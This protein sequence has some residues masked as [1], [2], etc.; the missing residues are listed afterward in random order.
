M[1]YSQQ[2]KQVLKQVP[3]IGTRSAIDRKVSVF[4]MVES[5]KTTV[6]GFLE[7]T[8]ID[9]TQP[10]NPKGKG[11]YFIPKERTSGI[12]ATAS[13]LRN[14]MF[15]KPTPMGNIF[16]ADF[17]MRWETT[18][19]RQFVRLP[20]AETAGEE[21]QKLIT[22]FQEGQ[23]DLSTRDFTQAGLIYEN[24]LRANGFIIIAPCTRIQGRDGTAVEEET[25][26]VKDPDVNIARLLECIYN[27][28]QDTQSGAPG[29]TGIAVLLTKYD[30]MAPILTEQGMDLTSPIG[31]QNFMSTHFK[32]TYAILKWYG[33]NKVRFWPTWVELERDRE[34]NLLQNER[35]YQIARHG[36][37]RVP[38]Y[39]CPSYLELIDWVRTTFP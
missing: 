7:L 16:E 19:N 15:P 13:D 30:A 4:G 22:R 36:G 32:E 24:I 9:L 25:A 14:G 10:G 12:R 11:F 5:G 3:V 27:Y 33:L 18:F 37:R 17:L 29:I 6:L 38:K 26:V 2:L 39:S 28:K 1:S 21:I 20:F 35:G 34:G 23:Y 31:V 8:C